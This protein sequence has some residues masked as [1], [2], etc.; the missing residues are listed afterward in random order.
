[1]SYEIESKNFGPIAI[2]Q[3]LAKSE[4]SVRARETTQNHLPIF[5]SLEV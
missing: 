5:P 2:S 4:N 3:H 1:M